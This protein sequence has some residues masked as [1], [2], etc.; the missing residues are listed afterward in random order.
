MFPELSDSGEVVA[1]SVTV[2]CLET[3]SRPRALRTLSEGVIGNIIKKQSMIN[4]SAIKQPQDMIVI[5]VDFLRF[6][7]NSL[8]LVIKYTPYSLSGKDRQEFY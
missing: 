2:S 1:A 5:L 4:V 3:L 7:K 6:T 8:I